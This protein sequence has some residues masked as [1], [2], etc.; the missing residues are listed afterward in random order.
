MWMRVVRVVR[1]VQVVREEGM[2][3][4]LPVVPAREAL[5]RRI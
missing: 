3:H 5:G 2:R 4:G 1:V